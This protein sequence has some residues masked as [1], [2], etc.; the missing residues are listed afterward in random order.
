MFS[1]FDQVCHFWYTLQSISQHTC[2]RVW[3]L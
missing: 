1:S 2:T 3:S